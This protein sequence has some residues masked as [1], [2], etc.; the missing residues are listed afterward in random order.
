MQ[1]SRLLYPSDS[2]ASCVY[3]RQSLVMYDST[4]D[5][6]LLHLFVYLD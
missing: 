3:M 4:R 5:V 6:I 1:Y 2:L